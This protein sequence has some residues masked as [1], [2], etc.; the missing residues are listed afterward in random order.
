MEKYLLLIL[1]ASFF[2]CMK[3]EEKKSEYISNQVVEVGIYPK[4]TI[5]ADTLETSIDN[6]IIGYRSKRVTIC[7][8]IGSCSTVYS[9][10][11]STQ[12][13]D[14]ITDLK[15]LSEFEQVYQSSKV[16][17]LEDSIQYNTRL[18]IKVN[19]KN[20]IQDEICL[21]VV[22]GSVING[23]NVKELNRLRNWIQ[24]KVDYFNE[25]KYY[26][27]SIQSLGFGS[28]DEWVECDNKQD[29]THDVA[30]FNIG[31]RKGIEVSPKR[32]ENF[33]SYIT[34]GYKQ[35]D[36]LTIDER[37][38]NIVQY[39]KQQ[40]GLIDT[41]SN[42]DVIQELESIYKGSPYIFFSGKKHSHDDCQI[43]VIVHSNDKKNDTI[44]FGNN[45]GHSVNSEIVYGLDRLFNMIRYHTDY[46]N[47]E[48]Y[49]SS[50]K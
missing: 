22:C 24:Y 38:C 39:K 15:F 45:Y 4:D 40:V 35:I 50:L 37:F 6:L 41:I 21:G 2:S 31:R 28:I 18:N 26:L 1:L 43:E 8:F 16:V 44:C 11:S 49:H 23:K 36:S 3:Y 46:F 7:A 32:L 42:N 30:L 5:A 47:E 17:V 9:E 27:K 10:N 20:G 12:S 19:Y 13:L 34:V 29:Y 14:T 25:E 48:K 33:A